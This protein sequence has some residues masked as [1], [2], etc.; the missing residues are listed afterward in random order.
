MVGWVPKWVDKSLNQPGKGRHEWKEGVHSIQE[1][2]FSKEGAHRPKRRAYIAGGKCARVKGGRAR[3]REGEHG[4]REGTNEWLKGMHGK[5]A[6]CMS[7]RRACL[8]HQ[9]YKMQSP[10]FSICINFKNSRRWNI[11]MLLIPWKLLKIWKQDNFLHKI[12]QKIDVKIIL[13]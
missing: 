6:A 12:K 10:F 8:Q 9:S 11:K 2:V 5:E 13:Y 1:G 7:R 3:K 4:W